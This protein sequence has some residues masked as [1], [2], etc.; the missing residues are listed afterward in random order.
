MNQDWH[1]F[2]QQQ[3]AEIRQGLVQH[4]PD[5]ENARPPGWYSDLS[6]HV[7]V[8]VSGTDAFD[9][10]QGQVSCDLNQIPDDQAVLTAWHDARGRVQSLMYLFRTDD[11]P[12]L[13][14]PR[15]QVE[16]ILRK[17]QLYVLR[18]D[19]RFERLAETQVVLAWLGTED[20]PR[21]D[22]ISLQG[23]P[24]LHLWTGNIDA[25]RGQWTKLR[26]DGWQPVAWPRWRAREIERGIPRVL[27]ETAGEFLPQFLDLERFGGLSYQ[28]GC[29][30]GQEVIARTHYLGKVKRGLYLASASESLAPG[31]EILSRNGDR[32]G[33]V[34]DCAPTDEGWRIQLVLR[35][36]IAD[37]A[38]KTASNVSL[39][40]VNRTQV[41]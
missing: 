15:E 3:G 38:A 35:H 11:T 14:L 22:G 21:S 6:A 31:T 32:A 7:P 36:E 18:A 5:T 39:R 23:A 24:G 17:L 41:A 27:P 25:A 9:F 37:R 2:L 4:F 33:L 19:V 34:L 13:L 12:V 28:K 16:P 10:L 1:D 26:E 30:I 40:Q 20:E 29:Y 8:R